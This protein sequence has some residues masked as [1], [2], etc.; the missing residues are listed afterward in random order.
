[1]AQFFDKYPDEIR[2]FAF[3]ATTILIGADT[4]QSA[5]ATAISAGITVVVTSTSTTQIVIRVTGGTAG[6]V[7]NVAVK[8]TLVSG[9]LREGLVGIL[10]KPVPTT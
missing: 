5:T 6:T 3:D 8:A 9:Q 1:M 10:I 7:A 2:D 4:I